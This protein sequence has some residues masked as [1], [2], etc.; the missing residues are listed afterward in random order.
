[1]DNCSEALHLCCSR[2]GGKVEELTTPSQRRYVQYFGMMLDCIPPKKEPLL[3]RS[4]QLNNVPLAGPNPVVQVDVFNCGTLVFATRVTIP[5]EGQEGEFKVHSVEVP[6]G[7]LIRVRM[8]CMCKK[9]GNII[10]RCRQLKADGTRSSLC[11]SMIHTGYVSGPNLRLSKDQ[12][13]GAC[14]DSRYLEDMS[15]ELGLEETTGEYQVD[16]A[17]NR[18]EAYEGLLLDEKSALWRELLHRKERRS[19]P[20]TPPTK[21]GESTPAE[22]TSLFDIESDEEEEVKKL[23]LPQIDPGRDVS[24]RYEYDL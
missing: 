13:D 14:N 9:Q 7:R 17:V 8:D 2:R 1:M 18:M 10:I 24:E 21:T 22:K 5:A 16:P 20:A 3:L 11:R 4:V 23:P 15:L 6:C 19:A 12:L